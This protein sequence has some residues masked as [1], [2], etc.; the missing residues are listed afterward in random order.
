MSILVN[1]TYTS[2]TCPLCG[3]VKREIP[4]SYRSFVCKGDVILQIVI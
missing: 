4:L 1:P 2:R 3:Y